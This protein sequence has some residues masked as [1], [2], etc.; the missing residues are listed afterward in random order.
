MNTALKTTAPT[1]ANKFIASTEANTQIIPD[2]WFD[3]MTEQPFYVTDTSLEFGA[4]AILYDSVFG[5]TVPATFPTMP[6]KDT[7]QA[8]GIQ[9]FISEESVNAALTGLLEKHPVDVLL[10]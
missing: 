9:V 5:E 4:R 7:A 1:L 10:T 6:Y 2:L 8:S 3:W